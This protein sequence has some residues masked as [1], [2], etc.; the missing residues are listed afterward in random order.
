MQFPKRVKQHISESASFKIFNSQIPDNWIIR[1]VSEKDYGVDCYVEIV[2]LLNEV[3]G[4]LVSIQLKAIKK[5]EWTKEE[6]CT[7]SNIKLSTTNY[8]YQ[9]SVPVYLCLVD[10]SEKKVYFVSVKQEIRKKYSMY[11]RQKQF[12]YRINK[13]NRIY[14]DNLWPLM[15]SYR[16]DLSFSKLE[17]NMVMFISNYQKYIDF[18]NR[19]YNDINLDNIGLS[20][21]IFL[22]QLNENVSNLNE[23]FDESNTH[24]EQQGKTPREKLENVASTPVNLS[25]VCRQIIDVLTPMLLRIKYQIEVSEKEYWINID[26]ELYKVMAFIGERGDLPKSW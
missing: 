10:L 17:T 1:E 21:L 24:L 5:I 22:K 26:P 6:Y 3:T 8:W 15:L 14:I 11:I 4:Y 7:I 25:I 13:R 2:S 18:C 20:D 9:F 23:M 19:Y 16:R 12:S